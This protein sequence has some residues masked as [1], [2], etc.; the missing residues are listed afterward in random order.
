MV[1]AGF[2]KVNSKR[3]FNVLTEPDNPTKKIIIMSHGF[4][5][6]SIGPARSFV[7]FENVLIK[8]GY[9]VLRFDQPGCGN[10]EGDFLDS[11]FN[12]WVET[13]VYFVKKYLNYGYQVFLLGQ[14][15]GAIA[16][17]IAVSNK[18][19]RGKINCLL[20]W[21]PDPKIGISVEPDKT[22]EENGQV[23]KGSF[24]TEVSDSNF[25]KCLN[26]FDGAVHLVYGEKD[27]YINEQE[28]NE[29]IN[30]VK[31]KQQPY[32]I[33]KGQDHSPWDYEVA[34]KVFTEQIKFLQKHSK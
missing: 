1:V 10:S 20:L 11:S 23:Y 19:I 18:E 17:V 8:S 28:R 13:I 16:S 34:Q 21:V 4:R 22:Y 24:W 2:K 27:R 5:G 31:K 7:N 9:S 3:I 30:I 6:S 32:L 14:S 15:M 29:V 26:D 12:D 25:I 33:L